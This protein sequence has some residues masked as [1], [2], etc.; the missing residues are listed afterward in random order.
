MNQQFLH[1]LQQLSSK[2]KLSINEVLERDSLEPDQKPK[3]PSD[4]GSRLYDA[5]VGRYQRYYDSEMQKKSAVDV[6][7]TERID[8]E[9]E[10]LETAFGTP[11]NPGPIL[12]AVQSGEITGKQ[13]SEMARNW[14]NRSLKNQGEDQAQRWFETGEFAANTA[15]DVATNALTYTPAYPV[16]AGIKATKAAADY[17]KSKGVL[18]SYRS[19]EDN[20]GS[21]VGGAIEAGTLG[22]IKYAKPIAT[23][24]GA[25]TTKAGKAVIGAIPGGKSALE[26][27]AKI[28]SKVSEK[29]SQAATAV[30]NTASRA[31]QAVSNTA[32]RVIP[33]RIKDINASTRTALSNINKKFNWDPAG[34]AGGGVVASYSTPEDAPLTTRLANIATGIAVGGKVAPG[35]IKPFEPAFANSALG[36]G[37]SRIDSALDTAKGLAL[38]LDKMPGATVRGV[39]DDILMKPKTAK[40]TPQQA[41]IRSAHAAEQGE[42]RVAGA[43][44]MEQGE[45]RVAGA[46]AA[47]QEEARIAAE[48]ARN[49]AISQRAQE[50]INKRLR[51]KNPPTNPPEGPQG[52]Q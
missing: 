49:K 44:A 21:A 36:R 3:A 11:E 29:T 7:A 22:T 33:Q 37:V 13:A 39:V 12:R 9:I 35:L 31:T 8:R 25:A 52:E 20:Y 40:P 5:T 34:A 1:H 2:N 50:L 17:G 4:I 30:S 26:K 45:A 16:A 38:N 41:D 28:T 10:E 15:T 18:A 42:A 46:H 19:D 32:S 47:E 51:E 27:T 48:E 6:A 24:T 14:K 43:H 23:V